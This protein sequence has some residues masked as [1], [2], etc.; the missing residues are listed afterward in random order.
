MVVSKVNPD[1]CMAHPVVALTDV[2]DDGLVITKGHEVI[3]HSVYYDQ[4]GM[5]GDSLADFVR[6]T[7]L[8]IECLSGVRA[9]QLGVPNELIEV[10][11]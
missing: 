4:C 3:G 6:K 10:N 5:T 2:S 11:P 1:R 8:K 7:G 9:R